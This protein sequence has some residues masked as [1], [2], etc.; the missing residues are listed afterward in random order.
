MPDSLA[1]QPHR[2]TVQKD[3]LDYN[4]HLNEAYYVLVFSH[5]SDSFMDQ[6][7]M[8]HL[9]PERR[10]VNS[11]YTL[12]THI[13]YLQECGEGTPLEVTL[14]L[15]DWDEKRLHYIQSM[16]A[17]DSGLLLATAEMMLLHVDMTGPKAAPFPG[18][19]RSRVEAVWAAHKDLPRPKQAG[20]TIAI[21]RS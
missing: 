9:A 4:G 21:R 10:S 6:I 20:R 15:L 18:D 8:D 16:V 12:E 11:L 13:C 2:E 7:G 14:Q 19:V 17:T 5:A 3:W 1:L